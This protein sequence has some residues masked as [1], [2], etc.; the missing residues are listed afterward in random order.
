MIASFCEVLVKGMG[1]A[2][3][4]VI[5]RKNGAD[6]KQRAVVRIDNPVR[7]EMCLEC[8]SPLECEALVEVPPSACARQSQHLA[9]LG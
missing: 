5:G 9:Y 2:K 3:P 1:A 8:A 7:G 6:L 4:G